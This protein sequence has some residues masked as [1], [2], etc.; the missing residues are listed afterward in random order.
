M[1][2]YGLT[3]EEFINLI[4]ENGMCTKK[5]TKSKMKDFFRGRD[6]I[7]EKRRKKNDNKKNNNTL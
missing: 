5:W 7:I 6:L 3:K 2:F 1:N 4:K